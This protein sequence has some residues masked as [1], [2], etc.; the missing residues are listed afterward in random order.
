MINIKVLS[1][2][3]EVSYQL[4][5]S[6]KRQTKIIGISDIPN[7]FDTKISYDSGN[8]PLFAQQNAYGIQRIIQRDS[9]TIAFVQ[10]INPYVN[11]L[12]TNKTT[13]DET[14]R[15][16]MGIKHIT[17]K[18]TEVIKKAGE[19]TCYHNIHLPNLLLAVSI[20]RDGKGFHMSNSGLLCYKEGFITDQTQLY[21]F[22]FSNTYKDSSYGQICWG[23]QRVTITD[24]SQAV[25]VI[26]TFLGAAMNHHL[27]ESKKING[28]KTSCSSQILAYLAL[29]SKEI[30][31]F[32]YEAI[33]LKPIIKYA[34]L[35]SYITTNWK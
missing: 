5:N 16:L 13:L 6:T 31:H 34:D 22:P 2:C 10:C 18:D 23:D 32:P 20:K 12:H 28:F 24:V 29:R 35:V 33:D 25:G 21:V 11:V 4:P 3:A 30:E 15:D 1:N 26:H 8:L 27:Y 14:A 17:T 19:Y 9:Q 7:L